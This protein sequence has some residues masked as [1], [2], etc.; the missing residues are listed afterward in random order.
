M[1]TLPPDTEGLKNDEITISKQFL[2]DLI[3]EI[4][5]NSSILIP[6]QLKYV[7]ANKNLACIIGKTPIKGASWT[8]L[9]LGTVPYS[10]RKIDVEA[11]SSGMNTKARDMAKEFVR[12]ITKNL[13]Q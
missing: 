12:I 3:T 4:F 13:G 6:G 11:T 5:D 10:F 8:A 2:E 7:D 9:I 1:N